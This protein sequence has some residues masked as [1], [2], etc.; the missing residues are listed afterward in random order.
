MASHAD[1]WS[2]LV[3][4]ALLGL[5]GP[6]TNVPLTADLAWIRTDNGETAAGV[7]RYIA[8]VGAWARAGAQPGTAA[9]V[10]P[11]CASDPL[12]PSDSIGDLLTPALAGL[13]PE[14]CRVAEQAGRCVD[15][16]ILPAVLDYLVSERSP[17]T[18]AAL[19]RVLGARGAWLAQQ[20]PAWQVAREPDT[21]NAETVWEVGT[22]AERLALL[23]SLRALDPAA[24][25]RL[26]ASTAAE[27]APND[28][29]SF[30]AALE[31]GLSMDDHDL[32]ERLLDARHKPVRLAAAK[33]LGRLPG[34]ARSARMADRLARR[35]VIT[36]AE[37]RLVV[38]R[39]AALEAVLPDDEMDDEEAALV[40]DGIETSAKSGRL[41]RKANTLLQIVAAA[42]FG[43]YTTRWDVDPTTWIDAALNGSFAEA[44][45]RGWVEAV[46]A[47]RN[48]HWGT[49]LLAALSTHPG[50]SAIETVDTLQD[51]LVAALGPAAREAYLLDLLARDPAGIVRANVVRQ[52]ESADHSWSV[53]LTERVLTAARKH[54]SQEASSTLLYALRR[55]GDR[56]APE[57]ADGIREGWPTD[58]RRWGA[59]DQTMVDHLAATLDLRRRYLKELTT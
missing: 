56:L 8:A 26:V 24:A 21:S 57:A 4:S 11:R 2:A 50:A 25:L 15:H 32:L 6:P 59:H 18:A 42:P 43:W 27:D 54:Y 12:R 23:H 13:I 39:K 33:L 29:A 28:V 55:W 35:L 49:A 53:K 19:R 17:E 22:R 20:N 14:W 5:D 44:I 3:T 51:H 46:A 31:H 36:P 1:S 34:S 48:D 45:V 40:R 10:H 58:A 9:A 52:V 47:Q 16:A 41:G 37:R 30:V 7:R 38:R